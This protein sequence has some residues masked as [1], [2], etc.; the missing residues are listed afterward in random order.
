[1]P[2]PWN[3]GSSKAR[4]RFSNLCNRLDLL[5]KRSYILSMA[6]IKSALEIALER[7]EGMEADRSKIA[8]KALKIE[9]RKAILTFLE[10]RITVKELSKTLKQHKGDEL[11]AFKLG[12]AESL[13]SYVKLPSDDSYKTTFQKAAEGLSAISD[14]PSDVEQM[15]SQLGQFFDQYIENRDQM[16]KQLTAQFEPI[17]K[18]K[19]E[20]H[21]AQTGNQISMNPLDDPDFQKAFTQNM[22]NLTQN[23]S[24]A[25]VQAKEKLKE[26]LGIAEK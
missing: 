14:S 18:Q 9:G 1:M 15:L 16:A 2:K 11:T 26:F 13:M 4:Y 17:L 5:A 7:T 6:E 10:N 19:E 24:D 20:A 8:A 12:A 25:L 21:Y 22:G 3:R 23:Y